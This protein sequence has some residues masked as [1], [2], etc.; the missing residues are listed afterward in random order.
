MG[1]ELLPYANEML[2]IMQ[3]VGA[4]GKSSKEISGTLKVGVLESLLFSTMV[5]VLPKYKDQY[6]NIDIQLKQGQMADLLLLLKQN[7]LDMIYISG[8]LNMDPD[9]FCCYKRQERLIF[10]ASPRHELAQK[11]HV[12]LSELLSYSL[13]VTEQSG[14]CYNRLNELATAHNLE[15]CYSLVVDSTIVIGELISKDMGISFLPE[16]SISQQIQRG[17]L[18]K[19]DIDIDPLIYYSQILYHKSK[20]IAPFMGSMISLIKES[21]PER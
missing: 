20:W 10:V 21:R 11:Q 4:L 19:I 14:F 16:Y 13:I 7:Q 9:L 18:V 8:N 3:Q 2:H 1:K 6:R 5:E 12:P 15:L 17:N